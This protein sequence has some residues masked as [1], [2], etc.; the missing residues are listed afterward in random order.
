LDVYIK[1]DISDSLLDK[2]TKDIET[3]IQFNRIKRFWQ[4]YTSPSKTNTATEYSISGVISSVT[5]S[6]DNSFS[7]NAHTS[8]SIYVNG[9]PLMD[10]FDIKLLPD[11]HVLKSSRSR[12]N[13]TY[14]LWNNTYSISI[15]Y[16]DV[17][18]VIPHINKNKGEWEIVH[19]LPSMSRDIIATCKCVFHKKTF[20][21]LNA[22]SKKVGG[23][24]QL[25]G[26]NEQ[27]KN[28]SIDSPVLKT[29]L[30]TY[31]QEQFEI[32][33]DNSTNK[34]RATD[35]Y[36]NLCNKFCIDYNNESTFKR[37]LI[38]HLLELGIVKKRFSDGYY[39]CGITYK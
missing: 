12:D 3:I 33:K 38:G 27:V 20:D 35:L 15:I 29:E 10:I 17:N 28:H 5:D 7:T 4:A 16:E 6:C 8:S 25:L 23:L 18:D 2:L 14:I 13:I 32:S 37:K 26:L 22:L 39:F 19:I 1:E 36:K 21:N 9:C 31:I 24:K 30:I 34:I 11:N